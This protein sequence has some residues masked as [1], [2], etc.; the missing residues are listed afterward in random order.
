MGIDNFSLFRGRA[1]AESFE[2]RDDPFKQTHDV[3]PGRLE[4]SLVY[5]ENHLGHM[6]VSES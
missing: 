2:T 1:F 4:H 3:H 5:E 6:F